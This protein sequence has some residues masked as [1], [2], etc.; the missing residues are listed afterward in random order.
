MTALALDIGGTKMTAAVVGGDGRPGEPLTVSTP[1]T[2]VWK[3]CSELLD[4][5]AVG[6]DIQ[7]IGV[8][9]AG[10]VDTTAGVVAPINIP[11]WKD[12]F[13]LAGAVGKLFPDASISVAM[14]GGCAALGEHK[15]GAAVGVDD[16]LS[17]VVSTGIGGGLVLGGKIVAGRSGNAGH[18]G[19]IVVPGSTTPCTCGG[20]GCVETVSSGP[21]AVRW[22]QEQGWTG[23]T[24]AEL[25]LSASEGDVVAIT[26][27][28][29]AGVA[30]GQ[31][32]ASAAALVDVNLVVIGGGFAQAGPP[33]W[34]PIQESAALHARLKFLDGL[35]IVP[36][37]LGA[38]GTLTGAAI[39]A[40]GAAT[41]K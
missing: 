32:I 26:T 21:S 10:P 8:A 24:G 4:A 3:A 13:D 33:L 6:T 14:D 23:S 17:L 11:E 9:C 28:Q 22:A 41:P 16:V 19:H 40:V 1:K 39:L 37:K 30:L 5:V 29:R 38:V 20:L 25:A 34:D 35:E 18:I 36:A 15:F 2:G 7:G 12:G 27:L 31:A